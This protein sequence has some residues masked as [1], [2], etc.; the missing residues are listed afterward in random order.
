MVI[1]IFIGILLVIYF[2]TNIKKLEKFNNFKE[3]ENKK[4]VTDSFFINLDIHKE[5]EDY[6]K[7]QFIK[8]NIN[9]NRFPGF[10]KKL[11]TQEMI[12]N[13]KENNIIEKNFNPPSNQY[14]SI[15]CLLA[16]TNLYKHIQHNYKK[17]IFL[18]FEDDCKILPN[19]NEKLN[20]YIKTLP[21]N[22]DMAWLGYNDIK[23]DKINEDWYKPFKG[24]LWGYNSQ[25]HCYLIKYKCIPKIL[26]I[27]FPIKQ[28][29]N[30]KDTVLR[31]NFDK[32]NAYFLKERLAT[33]DIDKFPK[34]ERTGRKN[35]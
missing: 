19:F 18:I 15:C 6:M 13:L 28:N 2:L 34:S 1:K 10:N 27:L 16:H 3:L 21:Q 8:N 11:L 9:C 22:W 17:G 4:I 25:H 23:G 31:E 14:G 33:Q 35:G 12:L 26:K 20:K 24:R 32:F 29:F 7:N 30:T 5:R